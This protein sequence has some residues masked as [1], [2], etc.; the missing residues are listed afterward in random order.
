[1]DGP[2]H[3]REAERLIAAARIHTDHYYGEPEAMPTLLAAL[4]HAQLASTAVAATGSSAEWMKRQAP[5]SPISPDTGRRSA[6]GQAG[7]P[8]P[9]DHDGPKWPE[10]GSQGDASV[11]ERDGR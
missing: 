6:P 5:S 1:M 10:P 9:P 2:G 7:L 8:A 3:Y 4:V 11:A